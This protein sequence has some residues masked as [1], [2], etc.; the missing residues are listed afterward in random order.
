MKNCKTNKPNTQRQCTST[1]NH[2][3]N[4]MKHKCR[5]VKQ[6]FDMTENEAY[7]RR[8]HPYLALSHVFLIT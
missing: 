5:C 1:N 2:Y 6:L 7:V 8:F 4:N 3:N